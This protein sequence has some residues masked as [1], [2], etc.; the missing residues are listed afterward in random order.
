MGKLIKKG[1]NNAF[2]PIYQQF[3]NIRINAKS[4]YSKEIPT[5]VAMRT[6]HFPKE[7]NSTKVLKHLVSYK[8]AKCPKAATPGLDSTCQFL[9]E[10][11]AD[12]Y[13]NE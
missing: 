10:M 8:S 2:Y 12:S 6:K 1:Q 11:R 13:L 3:I 9:L 7:D 4:F 5:L